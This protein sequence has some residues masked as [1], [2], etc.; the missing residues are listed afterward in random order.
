[1]WHI[2]ILKCSGGRLYTGIAKD[3]HKRFSEHASGKGARFTRAFKPVKIVYS[4]TKR[5]RSGALKRE[6]GIKALPK[7]EKLQLILTAKTPK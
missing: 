7:S 4:E 1:M 3:I 6:A 5:T 2:Y